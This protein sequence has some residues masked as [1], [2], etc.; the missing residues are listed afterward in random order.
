MKVNEFLCQVRQLLNTT[1]NEQFEF[2]NPSEM[3]SFLYGFR[4]LP[5]HS[6]YYEDGIWTMVRSEGK[7]PVKMKVSPACTL[8]SRSVLI[9]VAN[10]VVDEVNDMLLCEYGPDA[11]LHEYVASSASGPSPRR[12]AFQTLEKT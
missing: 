1:A 5:R 8:V 2:V 6:G 10:I 11:K 12:G 3:S 9:E 7:T 4:A